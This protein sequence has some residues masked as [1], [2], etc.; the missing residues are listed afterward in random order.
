MLFC[1]NQGDR[2]S[3]PGAVGVPLGFLNA[4]VLPLPVLG[5][6]LGLIKK[7]WSSLFVQAAS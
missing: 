5:W 3:Y 6:R 1:R 2:S 4:P 7:L